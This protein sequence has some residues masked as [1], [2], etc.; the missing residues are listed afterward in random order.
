VIIPANATLTVVYGPFQGT[1][2][3]DVVWDSETAMVFT[4]EKWTR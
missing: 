1:R 4:S 3:M 2:L